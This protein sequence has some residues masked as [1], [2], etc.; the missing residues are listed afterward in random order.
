[1]SKFTL[2]LS[3]VHLYCMLCHLQVLVELSYSELNPPQ[4]CGLLW[5]R[6]SYNHRA[7]PCCTSHPTFSPLLKHDETSSCSPSGS[8]SSAENTLHSYTDNN[9]IGDLLSSSFFSPS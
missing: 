9:I 2:G 8:V 4:P 6:L 1:M 3:N 7:P 5:E